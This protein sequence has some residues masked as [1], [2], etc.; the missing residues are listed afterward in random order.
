MCNR[1]LKKRHRAELQVV[2]SVEGESR[3]RQ[4]AT[5]L[6]D[7]LED[8]LTLWTVSGLWGGGGETNTNNNPSGKTGEKGGKDVCLFIC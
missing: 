1:V 6:P 4:A 3:G 5:P 7:E 8:V 2:L